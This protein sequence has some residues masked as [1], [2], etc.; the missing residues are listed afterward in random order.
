MTDQKQTKSSPDVAM[1]VLSYFGLFALIPYIVKKDDPFISWHAKQGLLITAVYIVV[2][3][4]L[5]ALSML[6]AIGF[7]ASILS[8]LCGL[9]VLLLSIFCI[10]QAINGRKWG[11]PVVSQFLGTIPDAN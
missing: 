10:V 2:S 4:V 1:C 5:F 9:G 6:P 11:V 3:F 8:T 7:V